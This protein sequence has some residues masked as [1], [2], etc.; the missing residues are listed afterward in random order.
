[1][2]FIN[3][4][5]GESLIFIKSFL[6]MFDDFELLRKSMMKFRFSVALKQCLPCSGCILNFIKV[7]VDIQDAWPWAV[8]AFSRGQAAWM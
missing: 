4:C 6:Y 5:A 2:D 8:P 3:I 7:A 1:M